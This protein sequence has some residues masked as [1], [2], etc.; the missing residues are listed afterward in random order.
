MTSTSTPTRGRAPADRTAAVRRPP[1]AFAAVCALALAAAGCGNE[2]AEFA[3]TD[4]AAPPAGF[5]RW[6]SPD[7]DLSFARP[8]RWLM[9]EGT[10]PAVAHVVSGRVVITVWAFR[11]DGGAPAPGAELE[12]AE[13]ELIEAAQRAESSFRLASSARLEVQAAQAVELRGSFKLRGVPL[14][15]RS[16]HAYRGSGEYVVDAL[17]PPE[18]LE[19]IDGSVIEPLIHSLLTEGDPRRAANPGRLAFSETPF[20]RRLIEGER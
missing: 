8:K 13:I 15:V 2:R 17:G 9:I 19:R 6:K 1:L 7:R 16:V 11:R 20:A 12:A 10:P 3:L 14:A 5:E 18:E 4:R